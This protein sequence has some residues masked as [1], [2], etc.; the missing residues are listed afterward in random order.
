M[1]TSIFL[2]RLIGTFA[3]IV[4]I[5]LVINRA[6]FRTIANEFLASP[7]LVFL[8]GMI[9]LP[10]GLAIV[11]SHSVWTLDWRGLITVLGWLAI[12]TSAV[13][14]VCP[15]A[16]AAKARLMIAHPNS[17]LFGAAVWLI[18]GLVLCYFG[19]R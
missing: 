13:R 9:T 12:I 15:Q 8:S 5:A 3:L 11:L 19:Y 10:A 4:G 17:I 1:Q 16:V 7:A 14:I 18:V 2:A 6:T